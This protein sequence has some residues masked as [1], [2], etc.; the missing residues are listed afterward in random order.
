MGSGDKLYNRT[1][2]PRMP[3]DDWFQSFVAYTL[4]V[5]QFVSVE[6][7]FRPGQDFNSYATAFELAFSVLCSPNQWADPVVNQNWEVVG[8]YFWISGYHIF[9]DDDSLKRR[10]RTYVPSAPDLVGCLAAGMRLWVPIH[11]GSQGWGFS[12]QSYHVVTDIDGEIVTCMGMKDRDGAVSEWVSPLDIWLG[13][14]IVMSLGNKLLGKVGSLISRAA[15]RDAAA[16]GS[17]LIARGVEEL[18]RPTGEMSVQEMRQ[19]LTKLIDERPELYTLQNAG[20]LQ[21]QA[22]H[23]EVT[24]ALEQWQYF[25]SRNVQYVEEG[26][27]QKLTNTHKLH[28]FTRR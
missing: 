7:V 24:K 12:D 25:Y 23:A 6:A 1:L 4:K 18:A 9:G 8:H 27:V 20:R 21:G 11:P 22:L 3:T 14:K 26:V 16:S 28:E 19:Y 10:N 5:N 15:A 13:G 2:S 17:R